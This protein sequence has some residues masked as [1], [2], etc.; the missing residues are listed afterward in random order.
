ME[1]EY[2][3]PDNAKTIHDIVEKR[4]SQGDTRRDITNELADTYAPETDLAKLVA[5]ILDEESK[6]YIVPWKVVLLMLIYF[7]LFLYVFFTI[8]IFFTLPVSKALLFVF[9]PLSTN[10]IALAAIPA[11]YR[12]KGLG[13]FISTMYGIVI[14]TNNII[15]VFQINISGFVAL[16]FTSL[17]IAIFATSLYIWRVYFPDVGFRAPKK[18]EEGYFIF[19]SDIR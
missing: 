15:D 7:V 8:L 3:Y 10:V 19:T 18:D 5:S 17:G 16:L 9:Y 2:I 12:N 4:L 14:I 1:K 6:K 13:Y 11:I